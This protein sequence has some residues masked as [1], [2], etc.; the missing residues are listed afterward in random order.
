MTTLVAD[1]ELHVAAAPRGEQSAADCGAAAA[2]P[3]SGQAEKRDG[4]RSQG[5]QKFWWSRKSNSYRRS[6]TT[7]LGGPAET[8]RAA[9]KGPAGHSRTLSRDGTPTYGGAGRFTRR[10][11]PA[12][13]P[14]Q[15]SQSANASPCVKKLEIGQ[16]EVPEWMIKMDLGDDNE[17]EWLNVKLKKTQKADR[18][19]QSSNSYNPAQGNIFL[20]MDRIK[21]V[22]KKQGD[23]QSPQPSGESQQSPRPGE[24][25][26]WFLDQVSKMQ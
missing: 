24:G 13:I 21:S 16:G 1:S 15:K 4:A 11:I 10:Q 7:S 26:S 17:P 18:R 5:K 12:Q 19:P 25:D 22:K 3:L 20:A 9:A 23:A 14:A 8:P 2:A 6:S